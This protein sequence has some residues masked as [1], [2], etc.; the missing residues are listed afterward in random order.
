MTK[1]EKAKKVIKRYFYA[2]D[3][4]IFNTRNVVGDRM[5]LVYCE[6]GIYIEL[7]IEYGYFE[8]F[9]LTSSEF[10]SLSEYYAELAKNFID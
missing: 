7:C 2:G 6:D 8:V 4:G 9:G 10:E 1:L 3:C 5:E